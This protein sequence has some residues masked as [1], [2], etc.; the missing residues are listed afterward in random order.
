MMRLR[1][2]FYRCL[3]ASLQPTTLFGLMMI[4]AC[5]IAVTFLMSIERG[6]T[7][8]GAIQQSESLVRLFAENTEQTLLGIDRT[9]LLLRKGFEDEPDHFDLR[10]WA[11]RTALIGDLTIQINMDGPDG[12]LRPTPTKYRGPPVFLGN[13]KHVSVHVDSVTDELYISEPVLGRVS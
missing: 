13:R 6:K 10:N 3:R 8:E 4:A 7:L 1:R 11:E 12:Y 2:I 9:L 5:W